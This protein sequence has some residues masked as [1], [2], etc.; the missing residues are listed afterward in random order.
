MKKIKG[1]IIFLLALFLLPI[2]VYAENVTTTLSGGKTVSGGDKVDFTIGIKS[3]VNTIG[4]E[5]TL[6][7][8]TNV[9]EFISI[10]KEDN[11]NGNNEVKTTGNNTL[12]FTNVG[13]TGESSVA[14]IRFKVKTS[15]KT[16]TTITL[17]GISVTLNT[18]TGEEIKQGDTIKKDITIKSE[19][20]SLK[21]IKIDNK[22]IKGFVSSVKEYTVEVESSVEQVSISS[23][24]SDEKKAKLVENFGDR[25]VD[26]EYGENKVLI[27]VKSESGKEG[28]YTINIIRKDD[29][30]VDNNLKSIIING[31][32]VKIEFDPSTLSY[33][34]KTFK[35][36]KIEVEALPSDS[37][38]KVKIDI[39]K[40]II[41]GKNTIKI[42]VTPTTGSIKEY[43]II[44]DNTDKPTDT[45]LKNL[46]IK[47]ININFESDKYDYEVRYDKS[48]KNGIKIYNTALSEDTKITIKGNNNLEENSVIKILVEALDGSSSSEYNIKLV[49]DTRINFFLIVDVVIGLILVI[50]ICIELNKRK[51]KTPPKQKKESQEELEKTKEIVL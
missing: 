36:E 10:S 17:D 49:K 14:T 11:W 25:T 12:K 18:A 30:P 46:S 51:K 15:N 9:L 33:T 4:F 45:R 47:G 48:Y 26:L 2:G 21:S 13:V 7:Y 23:Q 37:T 29:R 1:A 34:I 24:L 5:A 27:K 38:A 31:G 8:D 50:L 20:N 39:P 41:I 6:K 42:T 16:S 28:V 19:D 35:L 3:D 44:I 40:K 43:N 32:T 22:V